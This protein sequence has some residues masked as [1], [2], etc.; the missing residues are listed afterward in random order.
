MSHV[1]RANQLFAA[2][3]RRVFGRTLLR[4]CSPSSPCSRNRRRDARAEVNPRRPAPDFRPRAGRRCG[5]T[6]GWPRLALRERSSG[7]RQLAPPVSEG[8]RPWNL[9]AAFTGAMS[10]RR[11]RRFASRPPPRAL[12]TSEAAAATGA[13]VRCRCARKRTLC[14][15]ASTVVRSRPRCARRLD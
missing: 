8:C 15:R 1:L 5:P 14:R 2:P 4:V 6:A 3:S 13:A 10:R 11:H 7:R 12:T 9:G